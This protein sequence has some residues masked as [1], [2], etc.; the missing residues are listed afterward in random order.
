[1]SCAPA[2]VVNGTMSSMS[3][4]FVPALQVHWYIECIGM[5]NGI[6]IEFSSIYSLTRRLVVIV[7]R[8]TSSCHPACLIPVCHL[9]YSVC[10]DQESLPALPPGS[11][12]TASL[13]NFLVHHILIYDHASPIP[14]QDILLSG[15]REVEVELVTTYANFTQ[16]CECT[17]MRRWC[18]ALGFSAVWQGLAY[19]RTR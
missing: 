1:M 2:Y 14:L 7:D 8:H 17:S 18:L 10:P 9:S 4:D 12:N 11:P 19:G 5:C 6:F 16:L 15:I 13:L 3:T